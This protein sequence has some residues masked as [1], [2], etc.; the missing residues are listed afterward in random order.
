MTTNSFDAVRRGLLGAAM[1][2]AA[3]L[4]GCAS[5]APSA[6]SPAAR[7]A[8]APTG[9]LRVAVYPGSPTSLVEQAPPETMRGVTVDLGRALA[10]RLGVAVQ[11]AVYPRTAEA[12]AAVQRGEA[13]F[14]ITNA[15]AERARIV[16]FGP[17]LLDLELGVLVPAASRLAA[18][19]GLDEPGLRVGVSLGSSSE[20]VLGARLKQAKLQTFPNLEAA[21]AALVAGEIDAFATNKGILFELSERVPASRVLPG[22]WGTEHFAP[23][24]PK[25]REAGMPTLEAF[26]REAQASG[27]LERAATRAGLRGW[28]A[29]TP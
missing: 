6:A 19:E 27:A 26:T 14:T 28:A 23:A 9:S 18:V 1:F 22:R 20:R 24:V 10:A 2:A 7:A 16:D 13:D 15:T 17:P 8:L 11:F 4:A 12:V 5:V 25:G 21:R 29:P 3:A